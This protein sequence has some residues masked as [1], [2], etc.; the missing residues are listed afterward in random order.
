MKILVFGANGQLGSDICEV[1]AA[2]HE[3]VAATHED[4]DINDYDAVAALLEKVKADCVINTAAMHNVEKCEQ[5]PRGAQE[6]NAFAIGNLAAL[7]AKADMPFIHFSSDYVFDGA[8]KT[9][10]MEDD[11]ARPLN[12][13]GNSKLSGENYAL[14]VNP[15]TIIMR[16]G[17]IYGKNPCRA[18]GGLNFAQLMLKLAK[19]RPEIR[20]VDDEIVTPTPTKAIAE[21]TLILAEE[22]KYGLFHA[23]CQG[24]CSWYEF[25]KA[26]FEISDVKANL[27]KAKPGEFSTKVKRP[28]WSVLE[29][30]RLKEAGIDIMPHWRDGL[31]S[32]LKEM[33]Y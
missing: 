9:P 32:Y 14:A 11:A 33:G 12:A 26:I 13:Y 5:D 31:E 17:G 15:K 2:K 16:V 8:K 27:Q 23:T 7:C 24:Q 30:S 25:A 22:G 3:I 29:N 28:S 4:T 10:Y 1:F 21:Q 19:E 18:K 6:T 20:V